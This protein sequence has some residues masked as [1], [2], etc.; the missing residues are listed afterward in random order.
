VAEEVQ[1]RGT[2]ELAKVRKPLGTVFLHF[3]PFYGIFWYYY[4]NK[5][6]ATLGRSH[7][8]DELGDN[9][10]KSVLAITLGIFILVPPFVSWYHT[11][12]RLEAAQRLMGNQ[13]PFSPGLGFILILFLGPVGLYLFQD[14]LNKVWAAMTQGGGE[15]PAQPQQPA[16]AG[17]PADEPSTTPQQ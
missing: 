9:P 12:K 7:G 17:L 14:N 5:E 3:I 8:T 16:V 4:V 13:D 11:W 10:G 2:Q 6:M 1:I 15:L